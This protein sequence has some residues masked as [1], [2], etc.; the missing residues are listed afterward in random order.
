MASSVVGSRCLRRRRQAGVPRSRRAAHGGGSAPTFPSA[1][2]KEISSPAGCRR[3]S[4]A[5]A[6]LL[7]LC[8]A[9]FSMRSPQAPPTTTVPVRPIRAGA[10]SLPS[11]R[12]KTTSRAGEEERTGTRIGVA[13]AH[14][15]VRS[16]RTS[17]FPRTPQSPSGS[18]Q[19]IG[20]APVAS[21]AWECHLRPHV[22][23]EKTR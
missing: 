16:C 18:I 7:P 21:S 1:P 8:A 4:P 3:P 14:L 11:L 9:T 5:D 2:E 22:G 23:L 10:C 6:P 19:G 12:R 17:S 13:A 20:G 15:R